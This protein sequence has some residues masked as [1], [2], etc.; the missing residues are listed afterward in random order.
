MQ[1]IGLTGGIGAG[2]SAV[3]SL[4]VSY[5]AVLVD[6]DRIAREVVAPG[7]PGLAA[8]AAAFGPGMLAADGSLDRPALGAVVFADPQRLQELNAIVHPLVRARSAE[9]EAAAGP[10]DVVVHDVPLLAENGLAPLYDQVIVVDASDEVRVDRL[11]RLRG[12][13][14][15]EARARMAAQATREQRL[16]VADLVIDNNGTPAELE[17]RVKA[18]WERLTG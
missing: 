8:V 13:S 1:R 16:A 7:T 5:G 12:M 14:E 18:V 9:L 3:S 4:L 15:P 10:D 6:S 2:K 17:A 11:V